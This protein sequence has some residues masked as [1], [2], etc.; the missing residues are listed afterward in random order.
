MSQR[1]IPAFLH[2]KW[3]LVNQLTDAAVQRML[4]VSLRELCLVGNPQDRHGAEARAATWNTCVCQ[5]LHD[6]IADQKGSCLDLFLHKWVAS[7]T[8]KSLWKFIV[9][10]AWLKKIF[11]YRTEHNSKVKVSVFWSGITLFHLCH[12]ADIQQGALLDKN[13]KCLKFNFKDQM[14]SYF[15]LYI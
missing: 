2:H 1:V 4:G 10:T 14:C 5:T 12:T 3:L 8:A 13:L 11:S 7:S 15:K 9:T 6:T